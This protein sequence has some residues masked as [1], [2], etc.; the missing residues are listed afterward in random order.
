MPPICV[1]LEQTQRRIA[2]LRQYERRYL[3]REGEFICEHYSACAASVPAYHDFREG[4]MS[5][6]GHGFD[7]RL[8]DKPL[9]V[10][11]VGQESGYDKNR[12]EFRRRVT[13]EARYRQIYE[14]SGLKSRYSATPGYETRNR[15]MKGT[16]SALRLIF[17]KGL[18]PD[19]GGEWVSPANGEPFHIF[20]GFAL[21]NRL[22]CYAGLP[23]GS[24]G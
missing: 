16:T 24:N 8:G 10:V 7:L 5:H 15:H 17:G 13:V 20:D 2:L 18:G 23:E 14:L 21:V 22:L 12:S 1:D 6:V 4:T 11:V 9:R 19:Y 3:L